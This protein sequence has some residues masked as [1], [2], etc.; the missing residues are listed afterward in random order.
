MQTDKTTIDPR[1]HVIFGT[2]PAACWTA[3]ALRA[4]GITV[5]AINRSGLR[6]ALLPAEVAIQAADALDPVQARQ[7][8]SGASVVYQLLGPAYSR[9]AELF[10]KLQA[11]TISAAQSAG[12]KYVALE[13]LYMLDCRDTMTESTPELPRSE[14]GRVRQ[15]MHHELMVQHQRG[16]VMASVLRAS[17]FYGP[18][19]LVSA[20]GERFFGRMV[21]GKSPQLMMRSDAPHSA[22]YIADVGLGLS[23]LGTAREGDTT[24]GRTWLAPHAP[25]LTQSQFAS[26]ASQILGKSLGESV[27]TPWMMRMIGLFNRDAKASIEMQYQFTAPF[28][29]DASVSQKALSLAPTKTESAIKAT[30][31]WYR[32]QIP[33]S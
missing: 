19:V 18:G 10:P 20:F 17:D 15:S 29:V 25:A 4:R 23:A 21:A 16:N 11:N 26:M 9:W 3:R 7:V 8:A 33:S 12:A 6:P 28:V 1:P 14:K 5:K 32:S 27:V 31:D 22:A 13:N 24:W 30:L 2:G